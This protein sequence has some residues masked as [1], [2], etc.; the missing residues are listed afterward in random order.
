MAIGM[1]TVVSYLP[2]TVIKKEAFSYIEPFVPN[3]ADAPK[4]RRRLVREDAVEFMEVQVAEKALGRAGLEPADIDL[5]IAQS[6]GG[7]YIMPGTAANI[8][9]KLNCRDDIPAWN[10]QQCCASFVDACYLAWNMMRAEETYKRVLVVAA[11][12]WE[13]PGGWGVDNTSPAAP[14][15]GDGAAAAIVSVQNLQC[16]FLSYAIRTYGEIY[17]DLVVDGGEHANLT[18][19]K[20][21]GQ[22]TSFAHMRASEGF[23]RY[24]NGKGKMLPV[25]L[26]PESLQK[27]GLKLEDLDL[28]VPHQVEKFF[29]DL[30]IQEGEKIGI[31]PDLWRD[32]WDKYGNVAGV[33]VPITL[34]ELSENGEIPT[35]AVVS[36]F[37]P[38]AAGHSPTLLIRWLA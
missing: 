25:E 2:D 35:N 32:T 19:L 37:S 7:R 33:D 11:T 14:S 31:H 1:E 16:E 30:W 28:I 34:S 15:V 10:V 23:L 18:L 24:I 26:I 20:E 5:I 36:L 6:T 21:L 27:A 3:F 9:H 13:A 4:E 12:A 17:P 22:Q 38:G 29:N 8:H